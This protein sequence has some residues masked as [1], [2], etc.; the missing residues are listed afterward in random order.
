MTGSAIAATMTTVI[1]QSQPSPLVSHQP[2]QAL[3]SQFPPAAELEG[4]LW[5]I[6]QLPAGDDRAPDQLPPV[7]AYQGPVD[8]ALEAGRQ[9][10]TDA[11][12]G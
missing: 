4:R 10:Q 9:S 1:L 11:D 6:E 5:R 8:P 3:A 2:A 7:S 12:Q